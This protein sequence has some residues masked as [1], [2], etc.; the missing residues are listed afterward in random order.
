MV[1]TIGDT[2]V[3][4][5]TI[6]SYL[7]GA[8]LVVRAEGMKFVLDAKDSKGVRIGHNRFSETS[9]PT[10]L[11]IDG[12]AFFD[13]PG[14]KDNKGEEFEISNSFFIQRL[15]D[16]YKQARILLVVDESHITEAR[17]DRLPKLLRSLL[18]SF[19]TFS[20]IQ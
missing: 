8:Q 19:G 1:L 7:N 17:A 4:K 6:L 10:K 20:D 5:S 16:L 3:G 9:V 18:Q 15:L 12:M 13:C 11:E 2:G 14:F